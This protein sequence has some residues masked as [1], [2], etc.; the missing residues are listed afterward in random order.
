MR[1]LD[2]DPDKNHLSKMQVFYI[3]IFAKI[4]ITHAHITRLSVVIHSYSAT[5]ERA[6]NTTSKVAESYLALKT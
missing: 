2:T 5:E 4:S 3:Y 1:G 6:L